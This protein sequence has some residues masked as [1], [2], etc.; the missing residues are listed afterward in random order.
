MIVCPLGIVAVV[1]FEVE[2]DA[3][4]GAGAGVG[5]GVGLITISG[6][7]LELAVSG[8]GKSDAFGVVG[9]CDSEC[10]SSS[11]API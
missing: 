3:S 8:L 10:E 11:G 1:E 6:L 9:D 2:V 4:A 5:A 7:P